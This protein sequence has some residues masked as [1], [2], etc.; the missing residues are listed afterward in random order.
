[1]KGTLLPIGGPKGYGLALVVDVLAGVLTGSD[2]GS[3]IASTDDLDRNVSA[4]FVM[5]V[6]DIAAFAELQEFEQGIQSMIAEIRNSPR[7]QGV[8]RIYLPGEIE[9]LKKQE[10][11]ATGIPVPDSLLRNLNQLADELGVRLE[12]PAFDKEGTP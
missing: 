7:A 6:V 5:Q 10:R 1:M 4:G 8:E 2:F 12:W 9:W 11:L 3:H